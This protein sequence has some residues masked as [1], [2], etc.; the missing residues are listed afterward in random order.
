MKTE[1]QKKGLLGTAVALLPTA[2]V[3]L[4]SGHLIEGSALTIMAV[5]LVVAY[6]FLDDMTKGTPQLPEGVD[7]EFFKEVAEHL[8]DAVDEQDVREVLPDQSV[9]EEDF[10]DDGRS[11]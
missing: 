4:Q 11:E 1:T 6:D 9:I 10:G 2:A 7:E 5:S 3:M 8:A